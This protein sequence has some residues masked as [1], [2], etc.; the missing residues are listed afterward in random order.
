MNHKSS[1]ASKKLA[2]PQRRALM[3]QSDRAQLVPVIGPFLHKVDR[4]DAVEEIAWP[5][6]T[7]GINITVVLTLVSRMGGRHLHSPAMH[8]RVSSS[9]L[10]L[11]HDHGG[12]IQWYPEPG[13]PAHA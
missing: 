5:S 4:G 6:R 1:P 13:N 8:L 2:W 12:F 7:T 9:S 10:Q 11:A 3:A